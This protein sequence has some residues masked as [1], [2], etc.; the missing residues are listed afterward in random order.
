MGFIE[1]HSHLLPGI[2]DGVASQ[3]DSIAM[4]DAYALAGFTHIVATPHLYNPNVMTRVQ[5]I[6]TTFAWFAQE[7]E[8]RGIHAE[9]G[10]ETFIGSSKEPKAIPFLHGFVLVEVETMIEPMYLLKFAREQIDQGRAVI[11]A[12][13]ERYRWMSPTHPLVHQLRERGVFFQSNCTAVHNG[14][15]NQYL[16]RD[17]IDIIAGD[18]H[19]NPEL[20][21]LLAQTLTE[22]PR[23][24]SI[25]N[26]LFA[27]A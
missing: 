19:G 2:D 11:L 14:E 22:H 6:R 18:N 12:H 23:V 3:E 7:A 5:D 13:I 26:R 20:P 4:L 1:M 16:S 8:K 24:L 9:L 17:L 27:I 25:M 10:S 21:A 15:V